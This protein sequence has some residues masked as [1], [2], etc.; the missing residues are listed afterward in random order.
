MTSTQY[1]PTISV[2]FDG[3]IHK[4]SRGWQDGSIYDDVTDGFFEWLLDAQKYFT[5]VIYSSRSK[6]P[7][8]INAMR[9]YLAEKITEWESKSNNLVDL[10]KVLFAAEKPA[11]FLNIDDRCVTFKGNWKELDPQTL[12]QFKPWNVS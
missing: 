2:D 4:Y 9:D 7:L 3:V 5:V 8:G 12:R 1:K 6:T 10:D 11:A